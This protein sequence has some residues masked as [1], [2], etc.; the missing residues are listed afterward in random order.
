MKNAL[1]LTVLLGVFAG[2]T[3]AHAG[4]QISRSTEKS[5]TELRGTELAP[6]ARI[7]RIRSALL[8]DVC[9]R[10]K[11]LQKQEIEQ[12]VEIADDLNI[13]DNKFINEINQFLS[14]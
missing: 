8:G 6:A 12:L 1:I 14:M 4:C 3:Q 5:L 10:S 13:P 2:A 7:S 9:V 11:K